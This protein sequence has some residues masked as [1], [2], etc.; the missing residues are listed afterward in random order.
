MP[1]L[2]SMATASANNPASGGAVESISG[3]A[4]AV[5]VGLVEPVNLYSKVDRAVKKA[6][7]GDVNSF[8]KRRG[9]ATRRPCR[10]PG[11][12]QWALDAEADPARRPPR[13]RKMGR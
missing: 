6:F 8:M 1:R 5:T 11:A 10:R 13:C 12:A 7:S 4:R 2:S 3:Q 9:G